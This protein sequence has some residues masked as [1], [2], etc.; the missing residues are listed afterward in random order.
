MWINPQETVDLFTFTK[1]I[2]SSIFCAVWP[3]S[4]KITDQKIFAVLQMLLEVFWYVNQWYFFYHFEYI[5]WICYKTLRT[6][7]HH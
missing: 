1:E 5:C 3:V 7:W 6:N 2:V 4:A